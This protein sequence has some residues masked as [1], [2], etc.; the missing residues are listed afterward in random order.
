MT[1]ATIWERGS[2]YKDSF[3]AFEEGGAR[4]GDLII[5]FAAF[6]AHDWSS[7][8]GRLGLSIHAGDDIEAIA[9]KLDAFDLVVVN[10]PSFADGRAF[11]IARLI[12]DKYEFSGEIR[13]TGAYILDQ[14]PLLQRCGVSTFEIT[15]EALKTGL[16]RGAWPD[17]PRYYQFALDGEGNSA[18]VR[19]VDTKRPWLSVNIVAE[20]ASERSAA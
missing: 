6:E 1:N 11:S 10:F 2:F 13:A 3:N 14:M 8:E 17:V 5:D 19:P 7:H 18:R 4:A 15:S 12:R 9:A 16:E 20:D